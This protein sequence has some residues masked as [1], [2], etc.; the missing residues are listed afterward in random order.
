[1]HAVLCLTHSQWFAVTLSE[2]A[3]PWAFC[4]GLPYRTISALELFGT[5][6]GVLAFQT[7]AP[8]DERA[9]GTV[10]LTGL[11]DSRVAANIISRGTTTAFPLCLVAMELAAQLQLWRAKLHL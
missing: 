8:P 9:S 6:L 11:T 2:E 7:A 3:A 1:M 4:R 5:L 10:Q